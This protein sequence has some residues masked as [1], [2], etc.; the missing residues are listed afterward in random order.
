MTENSTGYR[1]AID[2]GGTFIDYV[3]LDERD[4]S[5]VI[6]KH[7][8]RAA[9]L[10]RQ[11]LEGLDRLPVSAAAMDQL[12]HGTTVA[13]NTV[14]QESGARV[15]II[16]TRGFEDTLELGRGNRPYMYDLVYVPPEPLVPRHLR[17][18]VRERSDPLG[19]EVKPLNLEDLD[20]QVGYLLDH[21]VEAIAICFLHSY[22]SGA[23]ERAAGERIRQR[24]LDGPS[25]GNADGPS[26][27]NADGPSAGNAGEPS[28]GNAGVP[29]SL[30]HEVVTEWPEF[31]RTSTTVLNAFIRPTFD[32]YVRELREGLVQAGYVHPIAI[33]QSNGG[34]MPAEAAADFPIRTLESGPA[35]GVIGAQA[36]S[37]ELGVRN[38]ICGDVGGTSFDVALIEDGAILEANDTM[39]A[40]RPILGPTLDIVSIGA[41]GGSIGWVDQHGMMKVGP[42]SAGAYPGPACFGLGGTEPTV[43]DCHLHL[44]RLNPTSFLG[45]RMKIDVDL[46]REAIESRLC[47]PTGLTLD[48][49]A[50][51]VLTIAETNMTYAIRTVTIERG[52]DPREF[53]LLTYG[54]GGGLF[55]AGIA[56]ELEIPEVIV[57]FAPANF[58]AWGLLMADYREDASQTKVAHLT[59]ESTD[60]LRQDLQEL[61]GGAKATVQGYGMGPDALTVDYR[62]DLRYLGQEHTVTIDIPG[63]WVAEMPVEGLFESIRQRFT[64]VHRQLYGHGDAAAEMEVVTRRSRVLGQTRHARMPEATQRPPTRPR[65]VRDVFFRILSG[66]PDSVRPTE[67]GYVPTAIYQREQI[68]A[69]QQIEGPAIVEEWTST[70][71]VPPGFQASVDSMGNLRLQNIMA[72]TERRLPRAGRSPGTRWGLVLEQ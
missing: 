17:R 57:P 27:G 31:E 69:G 46:A 43:T 2:V 25:A 36:L 44:G 52:L 10:A 48:Q 11:V 50:D 37:R 14:I 30:S 66:S 39:V 19:N 56:A 38:V 8:A 7:P 9:T 49:A 40:E 1:L 34:V 65:E 41:G 58:S 22:A 61:A 55:A 3:L 42:R 68:S 5:F 54:G 35:G 29:V 15:G 67:G 70:T 20:E 32:H 23:H 16:T 72:S 60:E 45:A 33:M 59:L 47:R 62:A 71:V 18:G 64:Q 12:I 13:I 26:A 24:Y 21:G 53:A 6:E 51:G 4:G 63:E 28:A